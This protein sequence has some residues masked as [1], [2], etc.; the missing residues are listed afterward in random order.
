VDAILT[1]LEHN[2]A[3]Q[4]SRGSE[5]Y[6][7][8]ESAPQKPA[9]AAP[10]AGIYSDCLIHSWVAPKRLLMF[11]Q[12]AGRT[13]AGVPSSILPL[14]REDNDWRLHVWARQNS[15]VVHVAREI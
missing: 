8:V 2:P 7:F 12:P 14:R 4:D 9:D 3:G 11:G 10:A 6:L 13:P 15:V 1:P 5:A